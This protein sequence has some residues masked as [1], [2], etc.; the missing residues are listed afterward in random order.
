MCST[1]IATNG[2]ASRLS[3]SVK[4]LFQTMDRSVTAVP[5]FLLLNDLRAVA[6]QFAERDRTGNF[7]QQ[8]TMMGDYDSLT[9]RRR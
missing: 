4:D 2:S 6:P 9:Y 8:G 1:D 7:A 3:Q 5:P